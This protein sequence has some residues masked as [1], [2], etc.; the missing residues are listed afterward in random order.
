MKAERNK[1]KTKMIL[2]TFDVPE[3][4]LDDD[5]CSKQIEVGIEESP[6]FVRILSWADDRRHHDFDRLVGKRLKITI[7][8]I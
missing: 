2:T 5:G 7:E 4:E 1:M 8:E 3:V 6:I